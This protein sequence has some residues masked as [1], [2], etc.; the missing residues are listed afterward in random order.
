MRDIPSG[1]NHADVSSGAGFSDPPV[2]QNPQCSLHHV[3]SLM[4]ITQLPHPPPPPAT[5]FPMLKSYGLSPSL[6]SSCVFS[7]GFVSFTNQNHAVCIV[8]WCAGW[9]CSQ[10]STLLLSII[11]S[12]ELVSLSGLLHSAF[13]IM[14]TFVHKLEQ[15][16]WN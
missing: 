15:R 12:T 2:A 9:R 11:Y 7:T 14:P 3:P 16:G 1:Q 4:P 6:I 8:L 5:L 13:I 10:P